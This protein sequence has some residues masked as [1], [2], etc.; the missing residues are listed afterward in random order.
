MLT[1]VGADTSIDEGLQKF[2][3]WV[4]AYYADRPVL[5]V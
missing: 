1:A 2:A 4:K 3:D 5:E